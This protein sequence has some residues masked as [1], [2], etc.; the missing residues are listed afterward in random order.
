MTV[1]D[2]GNIP[3]E[4]PFDDPETKL[5]SK[6]WVRWLARLLQ[7]PE[8]FTVYT[9]V[10]T[11]AA[12]TFTSVSATGRYR[13]IGKLI[14]VQMAVTITTN[15]TAATYVIATLPLT[16]LNSTG[17][18]HVLTGKASAVSGKVLAG[19]VPAN[20]ASAIITAADN[21]YPGSNGE[22]LILSGFYEVG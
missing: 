12:G 4:T 16:S 13:R 17:V 20:S 22:T 18:V 19:L 5:P 8:P 3:V 7:R 15:G 6:T 21:T 10:I 2:V 9:P 11:A 1:Q 14:F